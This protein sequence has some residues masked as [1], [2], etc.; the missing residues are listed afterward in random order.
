LSYLLFVPS[1]KQV[2]GPWKEGAVIRF[3]VIMVFQVVIAK[4]PEDGAALAKPIGV[5]SVNGAMD[6]RPQVGVRK[7]PRQQRFDVSKRR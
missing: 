5:R 4:E 6:L 3:G 2:T 1:E 7:T